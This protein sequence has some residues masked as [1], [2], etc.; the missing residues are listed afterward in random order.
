MEKIGSTENVGHP[1]ELA[2]L[3]C[4]AF[5]C[6]GFANQDK[7]IANANVVHMRFAGTWHKLV[8][9]CGVIIWRQLCFGVENWLWR[10]FDAGLVCYLFGPQ[11]ARNLVPRS[12]RAASDPPEDH[13]RWPM[14]GNKPKTRRRGAPFA[15][16]VRQSPFWTPIGGPFCAPVDN[17]RACI[18]QIRE[19]AAAMLIVGGTF[20]G[21][22]E[23]SRAA[24]G[25]TDTQARFERRKTAAADETTALVRVMAASINPSDVKNVAGAVKQTM[26]RRIPGRDYASVVEEG[27]AEWIGAAVWGTGGDTGLT[28]DGTHAE[29]IA[30]PV[31]SLRREPDSLSF[32]QAASIGANCLAAW[33]GIEAAGRKKGE[34][35]LLIGAG[36]GSRPRP[37]PASLPIPAPP[38]G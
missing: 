6:E 12:P 4:D 9:D 10:N 3:L 35:V 14:G 13:N 21:Q 20:V 26:L 31:A 29:L 22:A 19:N 34:T 2:G 36:G 28:R 23:A 24:L 27:P 16:K 33:C 30:V 1:P 38:H 7:L 5:F 17:L 32:D 18:T 8:I 11:C 37:A 15:P 25:Q